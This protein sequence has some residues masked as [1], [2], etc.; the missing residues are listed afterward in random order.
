MSRVINV[1]I[2]SGDDYVYV[3]RAGQGHDG[4]F[5]SPIRLKEACPVCARTHWDRGSTLPCF[6]KYAR[7][8]I[9]KDA[10]YRKRVKALYGS[11]LGCFCWPS[12][13]CHAYVLAALAAELNEP[14]VD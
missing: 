8:R 1:R 7:F 12:R 3:G 14:G 10:E 5:G 9:E 4:Y 6:E 11:K 2:Y 13:D